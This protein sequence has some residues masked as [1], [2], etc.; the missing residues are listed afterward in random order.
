MTEKQHKKM[1]PHLKEQWLKALRSGKYEQTSG[2]LCEVDSDAEESFCCLGV[3][4]DI[5]GGE[6]GGEWSEPKSVFKFSPLARKAIVK[7]SRS[8]DSSM[9]PNGFTK[10]SK[11][12]KYTQN[13][14]AEMNDNGWSF[15]KIAN[16]IER[17]L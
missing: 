17:N 10:F 11:L 12:S 7:S 3:L 8:S 16:W 2:F 1:D 5:A 4:F 6:V 9:L 14:L 15:E 13:E